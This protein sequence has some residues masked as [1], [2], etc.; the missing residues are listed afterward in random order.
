MPCHHSICKIKVVYEHI[1]LGLSLYCN[2]NYHLLRER[3]HSVSFMVSF[4]LQE[5]CNITFE[6]IL[7]NQAFCKVED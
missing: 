4:E 1:F 5:T 2:L 7:I 3:K 6:K